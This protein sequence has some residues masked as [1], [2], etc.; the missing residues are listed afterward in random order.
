MKHLW[1]SLLLL[2]ALIL[3]AC[4]SID[5]VPTPR[6]PT[7]TPTPLSTPLPSVAT[8]VPAGFNA[9]NP[10]QI[11]IVPD[12]L[13]LANE[14][15]ANF[16]SA[17][18]ELTDVA[19]R[20]TLAETQAEASTAVCASESGTV[21]VAWVDGMTYTLAVAQ[22]CGIGRLQANTPEGI[23]ETGVLLMSS[24]YAEEGISATV[25]D[26][27][28]RIAVDDV[29]SWTLPVLFYS[30]EGV[31]P[32]DFSDLS[33]IADNDG[34]IDRLQDGSCASG[35]MTES[36]WQTYLSS[37]AEAGGTLAEDVI[38]ASTSPTIPYHVLLFSGSLALDAVVDIETAL[39][40][41]DSLS[42]R[43]PA[44]DNTVETEVD[45]ELMN[46]LFGE[47]TLEELDDETDTALQTFV[48]ASGINF[49]GLSD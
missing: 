9:D 45:A 25:E 15:L 7:I 18:Q 13:T 47:G 36:A 14:S 8:A 46:A 49:A 23:G 26:T 19:I 11:V 20:V 34:L 28:C 22:G 21:S 24:A 37:D 39:L 12:D 1:Q 31:T 30:A 16:E 33:D 4:G 35:G 6:P 10:I 38:I 42:G 27:I 40:T 29:F 48:E 44:S 2:S 32:S 5:E 41:L 43:A 3:G 17:L